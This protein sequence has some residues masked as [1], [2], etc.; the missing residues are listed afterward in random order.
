MARIKGVP[1]EKAGLWTRV[2]YWYTKRKFGR[3]MESL[4]ITAHSPQLLRGIGKMEMAQ[5]AILKN[6]S[7]AALVGL[8]EIKVATMV[9]CPF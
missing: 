8:A 5:A 6:N 7:Q 1:P 9:G 2:A 3:V 4:K